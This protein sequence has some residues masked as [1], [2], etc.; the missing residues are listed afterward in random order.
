MIIFYNNYQYLIYINI[1]QSHNINSNES[2]ASSNINNNSVLSN[3]DDDI[4][5]REENLNQLP[6]NSN[7][8]NEEYEENNNTLEYQDN[9]VDLTS[10]PYVININDETCNLS[11]KSFDKSKSL[12]NHKNKS[13][14]SLNS[15]ASNSS[16]ISTSSI[17]KLNS[18]IRKFNPFNR[19]KSKLNESTHWPPLIISIIRKKDNEV[20][21]LLSQGH[22][23]FETITLD[24]NYFNALDIACAREN[25]NIVKI[26]VNHMKENLDYVEEFIIWNAIKI[27]CSRDNTEILNYLLDESK[28]L[29]NNFNASD[30]DI[31]YELLCTAM[32]FNCTG[33]VK[34]LINNDIIKIND[35]RDTRTPL[36]VAILFNN[37]DMAN[38]LIKKETED[39]NFSESENLNTSIHSCIMHNKQNILNC[40]LDKNININFF[41][42]GMTPLHLAC[43][44]KNIDIVKDIVKVKN[45]DINKCTTTNEKMTALHIAVI[46]NSLKI[47]KYL[48]EQKNI[49]I[50][51]TDSEGNTPFDLAKKNKNKDIISLFEKKINKKNKKNKKNEIVNKD[52]NQNPNVYNENNH[53]HDDNNNNNNNNNKNYKDNNDNTVHNKNKKNKI[54]KKINVED[55]INN[56]TGFIELI[57]NDSIEA[58]NILINNKIK[59]YDYYESV[60]NNR[61]NALHWAVYLGETGIT[62]RLI[63]KTHIKIDEKTGTDCTDDNLKRYNGKTAREIAVINQCDEIVK[64][65][66]DY[67]KHKKRNMIV[68]IVLTL[69]KIVG[70]AATS[71]LRI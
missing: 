57:K 64:I 9:N 48:L 68:P 8:N 52:I 16:K 39:K 44:Y 3:E 35:K 45:C 2:D 18:K 53:N 1:D 7:N 34:Y 21:K 40:L 24:E 10:I 56:Y 6:I 37:F 55:L 26:I 71:I 63:Y 27:S 32:E 49:E 5:S 42:R 69:V 66:D 60:D 61:W 65:F 33:V 19:S 13:S 12:L 28:N 4:N 14:D 47:V 43:Q 59:D 20:K 38:F 22:S 25:L 41:Y 36:K 46:S 30:I 11:K 29:N 62:K 51:I 23:V 15:I 58:E 70:S 50:D 54:H 31:L 67:K 17:R